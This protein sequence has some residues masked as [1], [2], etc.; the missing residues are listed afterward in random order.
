MYP[1]FAATAEAEGFADIA[2]TFNRISTAEKGH[3]NRYRALLKNVEEGTVFK[4]SEKV[5]WRCRNCGY[6]HEG[7]EAPEECPACQYERAYFEILN[8]NY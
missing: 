6:L 2:N 7:N 1:D 3:E 5:V 8:E 4:R